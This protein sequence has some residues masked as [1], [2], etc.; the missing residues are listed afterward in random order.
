MNIRDKIMFETPEKFEAVVRVQGRKK[1]I[2][3]KVSFDD[4]S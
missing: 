1:T 3:P 4:W 2:K